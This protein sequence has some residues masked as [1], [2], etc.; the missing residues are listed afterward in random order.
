MVHYLGMAATS[1]YVRLSQQHPARV[2]KEIA[3]LQI[4]K[5][6][7]VVQIIENCATAVSCPAG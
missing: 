6:I 4:R 1:V 5:D 3:V 7:V 2:R